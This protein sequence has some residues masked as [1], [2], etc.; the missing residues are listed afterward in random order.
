MSLWS[1]NDKATAELM[2]DFDRRLLHG[3]AR[4]AALRDAQLATR[5]SYPHPFFWAGF[6]LAGDPG[7]LT[8]EIV[9]ARDP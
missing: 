1:V 5:C 7:P 3:Q 4:A 2:L 9:P 8:I 6:I